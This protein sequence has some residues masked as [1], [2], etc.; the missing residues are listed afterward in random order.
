MKK[1]Y[2]PLRYPGGKSKLAIQFEI[3]CK[4]NNINM[5]IEPY[6]G[7]FG[8]GLYLLLNNVVKN[9]IINDI[10][11]L[12]HSFWYSILKH[13]NEFI[14]MIYHTDI[15]MDNWYK[16]KEVITNYNN[17]DKLTVGF[18]TFFMNRTNRSGI[19]K[20]GVIGGK[21]Q[22][23]NYKLDA[24]FK[25]DELIEKI[26][27][28]SKYKKH[29]K[30]YNKD[31]LKLISNIKNRLD[32]HSLIYFDPPYYFNANTL[33]NNFYKPEDHKKIGK[34]I[35]KLE[36]PWIVTYDDVKEISNIYSSSQK[37][38]YTLNYSISKYNNK[39]SELLIYNDIDIDKAIFNNSLELSCI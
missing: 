32:S 4:S 6:A 19:I 33:Y 31:A 9:V 10:D 2:T 13:K 22:N 20:A 23:G 5:Y 16:Y 35:Q 28:I 38:S 14:D 29:I 21:S 26:E 36:Y 24:R 11:P 39:G 1:T 3:I 8:I 15:T 7:G 12:I 34:F 18:A 37:F 25:K 27:R 30:L 17:Y